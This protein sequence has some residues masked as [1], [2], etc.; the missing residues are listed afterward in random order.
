MRLLIADHG[1]RSR[2]RRS[3]AWIVRQAGQR[4]HRNQCLAL[5]LGRALRGRF[6]FGGRGALC[7]HLAAVEPR[8]CHRVGEA[9]LDAQRAMSNFKSAMRC[10][11]DV[12]GLSSRRYQSEVAPFIK[13]LP[14][15]QRS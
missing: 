9:V 3:T 5:S 4:T 13:R 10:K 11:T 6:L 14:R 7:L 1:W 2:V 15:F 8:A 12:N